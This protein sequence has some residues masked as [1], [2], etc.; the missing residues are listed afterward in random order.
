MLLA[1]DELG[2]SQ[3]GNNNAYCQDNEI[4]WIKWDE[5]DA[6]LVEF[7]KQLT[8]LRR[9]HPALRRPHFFRGTPI[10]GT[11]V[12]DII[13]LNPA[14]REQTHEDWD[15]PEARTLGFLLGGDAGELF[16][17]TGGRQEL[18]DGFVVLFNAFH[19]PVAFILPGEEMG[20][21]WEVV[22][23]TANTDARARATR[24]PAPTRS[25]AARCR[26]DP[27]GAPILPTKGE[28][29]AETMPAASRRPRPRL[30]CAA[31]GARRS[32][33]RS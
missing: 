23:D 11:A 10:R 28:G 12:K 13:W 33:R 18:D 7:V 19:E 2:N 30:L 6:D 15:F 25:R 3:N 29:A 21:L 5:A 17:S 14:G 1:G 4:S 8:T 22:I 27:R 9:Q 26:P 16:Y 24:R 32:G 20:R 31:R